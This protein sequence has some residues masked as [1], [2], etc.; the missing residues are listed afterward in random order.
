[1]NDVANRGF[2]SLRSL[3]G[4]STIFVAPNG[5]SA[6]WANNGGEDITFTDQIVAQL[7]NDLCV[8]EGQFFATGRSYG[9]SMSYSVA[10]S[11]PSGFIL[12]VLV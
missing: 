4:D 7:K 2:Y 3:A 12:F 11:R 1:M 8:D 9:G 10:C 5:L 6:G